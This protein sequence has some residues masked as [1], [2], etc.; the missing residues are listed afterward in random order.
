MEQT[1]RLSLLPP[2]LRRISGNQSKRQGIAKLK[3]TNAT[4][5]ELETCVLS[6]TD[7]K[8]FVAYYIDPEYEF[9]SRLPATLCWG[10]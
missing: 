5:T 1:K 10:L 2:V 6:K 4:A 9:L 7:I 3:S 8:G